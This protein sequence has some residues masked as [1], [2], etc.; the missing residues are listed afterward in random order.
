[1]WEI[2]LDLLQAGQ[3]EGL[4]SRD[5]IRE[6]D[7][8]FTFRLTDDDG[9]VYYY[10]KSSDCNSKTAFAPLDELGRS[11]GCTRIQYRQDYFTILVPNCRLWG[12]KRG[13]W[14]TI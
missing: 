9:K 13:K 1:M 6:K 14:V 4:T 2:M 7:L 3:A 5:W 11:M 8:P 10:G 12:K